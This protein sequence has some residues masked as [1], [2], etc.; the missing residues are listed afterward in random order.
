M[1][2]DHSQFDRRTVLRTTAG[3]SLAGIAG[4]LNG[5]ESS[6]GTTST[7]G[8]SDDQGALRQVAVEGTTL[9]VRLG[10]ESD[11]EQINLIQPN[12]E[13]FGTREVA[14]G[15]QQ[16]SFEIGTAY[17]PGDYRVIAVQSG[18]TVSETKLEIRPQLEIVDVGLFRNNPD[19]PW[20]EVYGESETNRRK[21]SEAFVSIHN[22][23]TGPDAAISLRFLGDVPN[24]AENP[25]NEGTY[26]AD[27]VVIP[28]SETRDVYSNSL[29]FSAQTGDEGMGCSVNMDTGKFST[30]IET[31]VSGNEISENFEIKYSGSVAMTDCEIK[32]SVI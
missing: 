18:E 17:D 10:S 13:L 14:T 20:D 25:R 15:V 19:K 5:S 12:G 28:A 30:H 29:P 8:D 16:V 9:V 31:R 7:N 22:S 11:V 32:I 23:G 6:G 26:E 21:D 27:T 4:C 1:T 24:P 2:H 3:L